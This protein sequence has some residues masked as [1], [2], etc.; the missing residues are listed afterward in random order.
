MTKTQ[1]AA[2]AKPLTIT[3]DGSPL[4]GNVREFST[5]SVG[6]NANGKVNVKLADG[7]VVKCQLSLNLTVVGSKEWEKAPAAA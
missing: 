4:S 6:W 3:I 2:S 5:G 1:F 7:S